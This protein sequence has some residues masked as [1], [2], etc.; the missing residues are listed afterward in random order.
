MA[1]CL[2]SKFSERVSGID[3]LEYADLEM[4]FKVVLVG[5]GADSKLVGNG[6]AVDFVEQR[7]KL[8]RGCQ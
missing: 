3:S 7:V 2:F 8:T 1:G 4:I 6:L 5:V